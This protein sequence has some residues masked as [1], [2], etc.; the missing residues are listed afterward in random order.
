MRTPIQLDVQGMTLSSNARQVIRDNVAK[1]ESRFRDLTACRLIIRPP[2]RRQRLGAR[3]AVSIH[4]TL[5]GGREVNVGTFHRN[6]DP[7]HANLL[8]ALHDA[9]RKTV[10]QLQ[11]N[12]QRLKTEPRRVSRVRP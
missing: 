8:F 5:P 10:R 7:R 1:L 2:S 6:P 12:V 4:V 9:F 3:F 11:R